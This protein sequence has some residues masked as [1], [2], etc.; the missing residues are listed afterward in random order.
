MDADRNS[1]DSS[2]PARGADGAVVAPHGVVLL[3][4]PDNLCFGCSPFNERGLRLVWRR[5]GGEVRARYTA[6]ALLRGAPGVVHGG[7]QATL[8]DETL[9]VAI[10]QAIGD[11]SDLHLVTADF[12]LRYRRPAPTGTPLELVGRLDRREGRS[13]F[14]SG[15]I[16]ALDGTV[17]TRAT[18]RWVAVPV[19][20]PERA[21]AP[22]PGRRTDASDA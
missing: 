15:E 1:A 21:L 16:L 8:L 7:I 20:T 19:A 13:Y 3:D 9:G 14:A 17:L 4:D 2:D 12:E 6:D 5:A 11:P 22:E 18:A 10:H